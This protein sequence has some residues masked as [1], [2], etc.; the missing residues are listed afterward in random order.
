MT[1]RIFGLVKGR[2]PLPVEDYIFE[3]I[4]DVLDFE[5]LEKEAT[6]KVAGVS[7]VDLYVTG[8]TAAT[9][10]VITAV[11]K[12]GGEISLFHFDRDSG[13]YVRQEVY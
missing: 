6:E 11:K 2:H 10:A 3:K 8:L 5:T 4:E 9:V 12:A 13:E 7:H 1:K